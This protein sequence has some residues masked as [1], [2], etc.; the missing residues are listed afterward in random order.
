MSEGY[1]FGTNKFGQPV[2]NIAY[3]T[4]RGECRLNGPSRTIKAVGPEVEAQNK[5]IV[6]KVC[7]KLGF[8]FEWYHSDSEL[9]FCLES[10]EVYQARIEQLT[11]R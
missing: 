7:Q 3:V 6:E 2:Y 1:N 5:K 11:R 9:N 8:S 4:E 10:K